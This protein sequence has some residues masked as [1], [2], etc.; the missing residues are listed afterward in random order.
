MHLRV[1]PR[2]LRIA[3]LFA[4]SPTAGGPF[5]SRFR[6]RDRARGGRLGTA[7]KTY[8]ARTA[9][10]C[11]K[12]HGAGIPGDER[13]LGRA[14]PRS[15]EPHRPLEDPGTS[16]ERKRSAYPCI[17]S[18]SDCREIAHP[19]FPPESV[20][21]RVAALWLRTP[22]NNTSGLGY[23]AEISSRSDGTCA[24]WI[25]NG[26]AFGHDARS[27]RRFGSVPSNSGSTCSTSRKQ[28]GNAG[29]LAA[30]HTGM[31][32]SPSSTLA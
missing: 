27:P 24:A 9:L 15:P 28:N 4:G 14:P 25:S 32:D 6:C 19:G 7:S 22:A 1:Q 16:S 3:D 18:D 10:S 29:I 11:A 30:A 21:S 31:F 13:F 17:P 23:P 20:P 26:W 2:P 5:V 12:H 8:G